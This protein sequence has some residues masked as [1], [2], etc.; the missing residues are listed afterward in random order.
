[1]IVG[2]VELLECPLLSKSSVVAGKSGVHNL[3]ATVGIWESPLAIQYVKP[4]ELVITS[5]YCLLN[6]EELQ[7]SIIDNLVR[8]KAAGLGITLMFYDHKLPTIIQEEADR[9]GFPVFSIADDCYYADILELLNS[10]F[11]SQIKREVQKKEEVFKR[12]DSMILEHGL[13]GAVDELYVWTGLEPAVF[14][15]GKVYARNLD[16]MA[17]LPPDPGEWR[18]KNNQVGTSLSTGLYI[19]KTGLCTLEWLGIHIRK[20]DYDYAIILLRGDRDFNEDDS[21]LLDYTAAICTS[22]IRSI[23]KLNELHRKFYSEFFENILSDQYSETQA[24]QNALK[25]GFEIPESSIVVRVELVAAEESINYAEKSK[26]LCPEKM[27]NILTNALGKSTPYCQ[28]PDQ[29]YFIMLPEQK[30]SALETL[31]LEILDACGGDVH[32]GVS[33]PVPYEKLRKGLTEAQ[34]AIQIGKSLDL[35]KN[36]YLF[37]ELGFYR[38]LHLPEVDE[39]VQIFY[40]EYLAAIDEYDLKNDSCLLETLERFI[41]RGFSYKDTAQVMYVHANTVRY[42]ISV[43]EKLCRIDLGNSVDLFNLEVAIKLLPLIGRRRRHELS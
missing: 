42:R 2:L 37:S 32:I 4:N 28:L 12:I 38:L 20:H 40:G 34:C 13:Q 33:N 22:E 27:S 16:S 41:E 21:V 19:A 23:N 29:S 24:R 35:R 25:L 36:L 14:F 1:M 10:N 11:Y 18:K 6:N 3:V 43:V 26:G 31:R 5:G 15:D 7:R 9:L 30:T 8:K 39:V 17:M